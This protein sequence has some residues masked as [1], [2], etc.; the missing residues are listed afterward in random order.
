DVDRD[1]D[2]DVVSDTYGNCPFFNNNNYKLVW[3]ENLDGYN[4]YSDA[5]ILS[6]I[7]E[8]FSP[9]LKISSNDIDFDDDQD[10]IL[11]SDT[12]SNDFIRIYQ[13][14]QNGTFT[15]IENITLHH[16]VK[17]FS[18]GDFDTDGDT[19]IVSFK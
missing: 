13:N 16:A 8:L 17:T 15:L 3:Y 12:N 19:D 2:L 5:M 11:L 18:L 14:D 9:T 7:G 1:G 4:S 10:I 6:T